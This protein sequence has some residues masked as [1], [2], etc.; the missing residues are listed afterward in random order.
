MH[1]NTSAIYSISSFC[2]KYKV[3]V[4][5]CKA[6]ISALE[7]CKLWWN[8]VAAVLS[9]SFSS[10]MVLNLFFIS[11][12]SSRRLYSSDQSECLDSRRRGLLRPVCSVPPL[13]SAAAH[14]ADETSEYRSS[15]LL[16]QAPGI[17]PRELSW[18][19]TVA[20]T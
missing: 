13:H 10:S 14:A 2:R 11:S 20:S 3:T 16:S 1:G 7:F 19:T 15:S 4:V 12:T 8:I 6:V 17:K 9:R 18:S 5:F